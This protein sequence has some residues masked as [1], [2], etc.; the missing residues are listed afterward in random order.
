LF[1]EYIR[2][3]SFSD[4]EDVLNGITS[5]VDNIDKYSDKFM[6]IGQK[7]SVEIPQTLNNLIDIYNEMQKEEYPMHHIATVRNIKENKEKLFDIIKDFKSLKF[8][9]LEDKIN[10]IEKI[11][12]INL[13]DLERERLAKAELD[14]S[15]DEIYNN[16]ASLATLCSRKIKEIV[17]YEKDYEKSKERSEINKKLRE[18][19]QNVELAIIAYDSLKFTSSPFTERL[20]KLNDLK[21]RA[22]KLKESFGESDENI[23]ELK[24][25]GEELKI[26]VD[27]DCKKL[28]NVQ[29]ELRNARFKKISESYEDK[30]K[31]AYSLINKINALL[32]N[33]PLDVDGAKS[34]FESFDNIVNY[35]N[36]NVTEDVENAKYAEA[37]LLFANNFRNSDSNVDRDISKAELFFYDGR[38]KECVECAKIALSTYELPDELKR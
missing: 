36:L 14:D 25:Y 26:K 7:I 37:L 1:A 27:N 15:S 35:L 6:H 17:T 24:D 11:A 19:C 3:G 30:F 23:K 20:S 31:M 38:F 2:R 18:Y 21:E 4:A 13:K 10:N 28:R 22:I 34:T 5:I 32:A 33:K 29:I 16:A 8:D 12:A 9:E